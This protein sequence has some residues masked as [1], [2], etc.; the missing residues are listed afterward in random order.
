MTTMQFTCTNEL[1][2]NNP[3]EEVG[4]G[5]SY[6]SQGQLITEAFSMPTAII[7]PNGLTYTFQ[8]DQC[9]MLR[10]VTYP[11]GGYTRYDYSAQLQVLCI[12][13]A[14]ACS[15]YNTGSISSFVNQISAKH[16]CPAA[17]LTLGSASAS[18]F[19]A[20]VSQQC[21]VAEQ[22]TTYAPTPYITGTL[23]LIHI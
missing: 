18:L 16:V 2:Q 4:G 12:T 13:G 15:A 7:L 8:F 9:G 5:A 17:A 3:Y 10:K 1:G 19:T 11:S 23:S 6:N 14:G 20:S 21:S 22:T